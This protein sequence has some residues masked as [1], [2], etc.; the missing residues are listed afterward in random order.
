MRQKLGLILA[1]MHRPELLIMDEPSAGLDPLMQ[2]VLQRELRAAA[3]QGRTV[4][5]SSHSL[6]EAEQLCERVAI[7]REGHLV[8]SESI[9]E[10]RRR[11]GHRVRLKFSKPIE[12]LPDPPS[13]LA[14]D[15]STSTEA[16]GRWRGPVQGLLTWL[17]GLP[18]KDM[19]LQPADLEDLFIDYY[20]GS[21]GSE[22]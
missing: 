12:R 19:T 3:T 1:M 21:G 18:L 10:L 8:A 16:S 9:T 5:F 4:L 7:L 14:M 17:A 6:P 20:S 22:P 2:Q 11:A 15:R 13:G